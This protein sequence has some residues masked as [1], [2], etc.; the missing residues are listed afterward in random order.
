MQLNH[1]VDITGECNLDL[2]TR[3][4]DVME[5]DAIIDI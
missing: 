3:I 4:R 1:V 5:L 2:A